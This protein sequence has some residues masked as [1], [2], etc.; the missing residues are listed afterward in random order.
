M[1]KTIEEQIKEIEGYMYLEYIEGIHRDLL[2]DTPY[3][4]RLSI[5]G[6]KYLT[7]L[8]KQQEQ[9]IREEAVMGFARWLEDDLTHEHD[10]LHKR[11]LANVYLNQKQEEDK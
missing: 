9:E 6:K 10:G 3:K 8:P 1:N 2:V 11:A 5:E 7:S 4:V